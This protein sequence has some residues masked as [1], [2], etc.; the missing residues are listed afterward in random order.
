VVEHGLQVVH[1]GGEPRHGP[2]FVADVV[3]HHGT[4]LGCAQRDRV[5]VPVDE[6]VGGVRGVQIVTEQPAGGRVT[7]S[8]VVVVVRL[9]ESVLPQQVMKMKPIRRVRGKEVRLDEFG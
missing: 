3:G 1:L 4:G 7:G 2:R 9:L 5:A 6:R 8:L